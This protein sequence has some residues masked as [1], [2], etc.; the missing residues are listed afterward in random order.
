[1][2]IT[3]RWS[4]PD[5]FCTRWRPCGNAVHRPKTQPTSAGMGQLGTAGG[6][7]QK[8]WQKFTDSMMRCVVLMGDL[9]P[10]GETLFGKKHIYIYVYT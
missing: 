7:R 9:A 2:Y 5:W 10:V 8:G 4:N 1:M 6:L 3:F